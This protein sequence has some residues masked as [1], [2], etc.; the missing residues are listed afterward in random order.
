ML[1]LQDQERL[2]DLGKKCSY[3]HRHVDEQTT[4]KRSKKNDDKSAVAVLKK[5]DWNERVREPF[6]QL[7]LRSR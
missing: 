4:C 5:G 2:S 7:C 1:A 6:Y 3:A